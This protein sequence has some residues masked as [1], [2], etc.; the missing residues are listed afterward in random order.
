M[1]AF[2]GQLHVPHAQPTRVSTMAGRVDD[3]HRAQ[4]TQA[5]AAG[6]ASRSPRLSRAAER[7]SRWSVD[8]GPVDRLAQTVDDAATGMLGEPEDGGR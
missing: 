3:L 8:N 7:V 6:D 2:E 1:M 5:F 4:P